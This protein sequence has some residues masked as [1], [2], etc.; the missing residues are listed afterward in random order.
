MPARLHCATLLQVFL[1]LALLPHAGGEPTPPAAP[2]PETQNQKPG[3]D[4][5]GDPLPPGAIARMGTV[6]LRHE[7]PA[8]AVAF[9]PDGQTLASGGRDGTI[10]LWEMAT[11]KERLRIQGP[12]TMFRSVAFSPDGKLLASGHSNSTI[13]IW[14]VAALLKVQK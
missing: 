7:G 4:L 5:Y 13:L 3:T 6:R 14:D 11:G 2:Q 1:A 9:S 8:S 12:A 10:R